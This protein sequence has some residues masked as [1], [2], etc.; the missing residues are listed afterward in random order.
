M[1]ILKTG[2]PLE[3]LW[4]LSN[5]SVRSFSR[6]NMFIYAAGLAY[7]TL[8]A[9]FPFLAFLVALL[10]Y[11]GIDSFFEWLTGQANYALQEQYSGLAERSIKQSLHQARGGLLTSVG[12]IALWSVSG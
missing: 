10:G 1:K 5:H 12:I 3:A 4:K 8:F 9:V 6:H 11:L 2:G 7:R